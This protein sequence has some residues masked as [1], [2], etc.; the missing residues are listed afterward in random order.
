MVEKALINQP[1]AGFHTPFVGRAKELAEIDALLRDPACRLLTLTGLGG[2]GKT[3]LAIE[4]ASAAADQFA[5]GLALVALQAIPRGDLLV[6]AVAQTLG[7]VFYGEAEAQDQLFAFLHDKAMLL[8]LDNFEHLLDDAGLVS[9]LLA[10]AP[11]VTVLATSREALRLQEEWLYPLGGLP[12]PPSVYATGLEAYEAVQLFLSHARRVQPSFSLAGERE[13]VSRICM[14]TAGLP[15]ALELA[16]SWLK[17]LHA[18][19]VAQAMQRNLDMLSTNTRNVEARH[20][21][22]RAVFDQSWALL[23]G[24]ERLI[25]AKLSVFRGGFAGEAAKQVAGASLLDLAGLVEKSLIGRESADRFGMHELL[26][27][28]AT[29]QLAAL[30]Q[31]EAAQ[32]RHSQYFAEFMRAQEPEL[33]GPRQLATMQAIDRD[34]DNIR[35]AWVWSLERRHAANLHLM[36]N[37]LYL[38]GFLGRRHVDTIVIF[39][40][41]LAQP[42][43]D[44]PLLGRL[45]ARRW[46]SLHWWFQSAS[47]YQEALASIERALAIAQAEGNRF[48]EAFCRL[49][50]GYALM[51][52]QRPAEAL[53]HLERSKALFEA[54]GEPFFVSWALS[55][56][57]YLYAALHDPDKEIAA[58]EQSLALARAMHNR[59]ALF[60]C[61][62]NLGSDYI[63]NGDYITGRQYGAEALQ[64]ANET[65]QQCQIS[66]AWSLLALRAFYQG[67]Y[68]TCLECSRRSVTAVKDIL[69]LIVQ[70]Y[71]LALLTLLAC[72]DEQYDEAIRINQISKHH[73]VNTMGFQLNY[74]AQA[75]LA[76]GLGNLADARAAIQSALQLTAANIYAATTIWMVPCAAATLAPTEPAKAAELLAWVLAYPDTGLNWARQW[77]LIGRL[78]EQLAATLDPDAYQERW[79][80]GKALSF[81]QIKGY[82][83]QAFR[84]QPGAGAAPAEHALLT[85][86]EREILGLIAAGQTNPQIAARLI[87]GAGT[88]KTHTLNIYRKLEVANRT[89]A[90]KRAQELGLLSA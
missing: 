53:A 89:Q 48:E 86:R 40:Q 65:E 43:D 38:F 42:I 88:V 21:S 27:Q 36:L 37:P 30:G 49:M 70:P 47:D 57:G 23:S 17:G 56:L 24:D 1:V 14:L 33:K 26:R 79:D 83:H 20:R 80:R 3:R 13:A 16:A 62:Y 61:L 66:H 29:E 84:A 44:P 81:E 19:D 11:G 9:S 15:L 35:L 31:A 68:Q 12:A 45:L 8:I 78:H 28:Y 41:S 60:S 90:L 74:W 64:F 75:A 46:G 85:G 52:M 32:A 25:F 4:A 34:F 54:L 77:P 39:Q 7:L 73:S 22:M 51:G 69:M 55:R 71:S 2:S 18:A 76:C 50:A 72:L 6:S 5:H 63:L 67:D 87:I 10:A 59:F 82:L 58:M